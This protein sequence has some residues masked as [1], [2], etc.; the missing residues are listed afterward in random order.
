MRLFVLFFYLFTKDTGDST[1]FIN[2]DD[3]DLNAFKGE[4]VV[5]FGKVVS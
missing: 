1:V 2:C 3:F 5:Y 4:N